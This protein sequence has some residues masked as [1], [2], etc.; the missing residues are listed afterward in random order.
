MMNGKCR[1]PNAKC[2]MHINLC[3]YI[4]T[5]N[6][7]YP[8]KCFD[9]FVL[10]ALACRLMNCELLA[11]AK[12]LSNI[13]YA[14]TQI[15]YAWNGVEDYFSFSLSR[16]S[17]EPLLHVHRKRWVSLFV[18]MNS[19]ICSSKCVPFCW[20]HC[21]TH[22]FYYAK[23]EKQRVQYHPLGYETAMRLHRCYI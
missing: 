23:A 17:L 9:S 3:T 5:L 8:H 20:F 16:Y 18:C 10:D 13:I 12:K 4:H 7:T 14:A 15:S 6:E 2:R 21:S 19:S 1:M 11:L 22:T